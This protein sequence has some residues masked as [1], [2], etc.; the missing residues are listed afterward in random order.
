MDEDSDAD[1]EVKGYGHRT[2]ATTT[3]SSPDRAALTWKDSEITGHRIDAASGDD[4]GEGINGIGFRPTPAMAS[5]RRQKRRQQVSEWKAREARDARQ[6]RLDRRRGGGSISRDR[7]SS[8]AA[9][10][11]FEVRAGEMRPAGRVVRFV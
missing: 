7:S 10:V 6:R 9:G 2:A 8:A 4:D 5:A 1:S 3:P 11:R